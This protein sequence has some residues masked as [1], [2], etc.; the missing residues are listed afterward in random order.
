MFSASSVH[1]NSFQSNMECDV[2]TGKNLYVDVVLSNGTNM[3]PEGFER[4][5]KELMALAPSRKKI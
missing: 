3:F 1:D 2:F 4:M 5:T